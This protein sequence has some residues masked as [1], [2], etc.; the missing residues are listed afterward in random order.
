MTTAAI[1]GGGSFGTAMACAARR[2]GLEAKLWAREPEIV[3]AINAGQGNPA[4]LPGIPLEP[5]I[6]ASRDLSD[7][8]R[9]AD[10]V[11]MAVPSQFLRGVAI[12]MRDVLRPGVAVV[13]R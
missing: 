9:A 5:G 7:T 2:A 13:C 4:F 1:I 3:D 6:K 10:F 8:V 12:Q 11:L